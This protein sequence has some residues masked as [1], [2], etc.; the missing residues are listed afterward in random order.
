MIRGNEVARRD[1]PSACVALEKEVNETVSHIVHLNRKIGELR[2]RHKRNKVS[3][4]TNKTG[5]L[6]C[7][8]CEGYDHETH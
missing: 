3:L 6:R 4:S 2:G 7:T 5:V 1:T 8:K